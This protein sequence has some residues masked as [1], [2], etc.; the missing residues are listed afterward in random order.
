MNHKQTLSAKSFYAFR[1]RR[2]CSIWH[3]LRLK[4]SHRL[5]FAQSLHWNLGWPIAI[6][7]PFITSRITKPDWFHCV[8][9]DDQQQRYEYPK[10]FISDQCMHG[11]IVHRR[12]SHSIFNTKRQSGL[13]LTLTKTGKMLVVNILPI[14]NTHHSTASY[15]SYGSLPIRAVPHPIRYTV[16]ERCTENAMSITLKSRPARFQPIKVMLSST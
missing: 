5:T 8:P 1:R 15:L 13:M 3:M 4:I 16:N 10:F 14:L 11:M 2:T 7:L 9:I 12:Y 6:V